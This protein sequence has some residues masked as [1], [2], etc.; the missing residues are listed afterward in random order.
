MFSFNDSPL[1]NIWRGFTLK[2]YAPRWRATTERSWP[3]SVVSLKIA[4]FTAC[5][6]VVLGTLAAFALVK[7]RASKAA[8]CS[9]AWSTRRW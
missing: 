8:R 9:P 1:P 5:G 4:F 6:S 3:A 2:W 7:Y